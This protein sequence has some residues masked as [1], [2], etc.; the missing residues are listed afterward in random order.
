MG[1]L[2]RINKLLAEKFGEIMNQEADPIRKFPNGFRWHYNYLPEKKG[3]KQIW[4]CWSIKRNANG[5][6][7]SWQYV[8][9]KTKR[10]KV[11]E[12]KKI[13]EHKL[14]KKAKERAYKM[15]EQRRKQLERG[16]KDV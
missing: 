1:E 14:K 3:F 16:E 10:G 9:K 5:K 2:D 13:R 12:F 15:L 4:F 6:F 7:I 8:W 11:A